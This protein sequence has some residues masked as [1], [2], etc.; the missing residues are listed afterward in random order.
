MVTGVLRT[1]QELE[2]CCRQQVPWVC[3]FLIHCLLPAAAISVQ[4][5][6]GVFPVYQ[7]SDV[8]GLCGSVSGSITATMI[9][10]S[11]PIAAQQ[12]PARVT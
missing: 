12:A 1:A 2:P 10:N 7:S 11:L 3:G 9:Q 5:L 8:S 6:D 4:L